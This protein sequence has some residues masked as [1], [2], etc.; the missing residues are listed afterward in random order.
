MS[1]FLL[2][3]ATMCPA[4]AQEVAISSNND[5]F[6]PSLRIDNLGEDEILALCDSGSEIM[7]TRNDE[8]TVECAIPG[9]NFT[10]LNF[11]FEAQLRTALA[12]IEVVVTTTLGE[13]SFEVITLIP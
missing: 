4:D 3:A 10:L 8:L 9:S 1:V 12:P 11:M 13:V 7:M 5:Q 6:L 2:F